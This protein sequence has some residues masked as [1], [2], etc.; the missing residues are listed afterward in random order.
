M[1]NA[2]YRHR[3]FYKEVVAKCVV[4]IGNTRASQITENE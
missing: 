1:A 2:I 4:V 3:N